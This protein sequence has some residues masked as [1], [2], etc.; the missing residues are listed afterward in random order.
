[1]ARTVASRVAVGEHAVRFSSMDDVKPERAAVQGKDARPIWCRQMTT[2]TMHVGCSITGTVIGAGI[3]TG[4]IYFLFEDTVGGIVKAGVYNLPDASPDLAAKTFP[5]G[6]SLAIVEP[7]LKRGSDGRPFIRIEQPSDLRLDV[8]LPD[9]DPDAWQREGKQFFTHGLHLAAIECWDRALATSATLGAIALLATNR[10]AALLQCSRAAEAVR[11]SAIAIVLDAQPKAACRLVAGLVSLDLLDAAKPLAAQFACRWP[12]IK[13]ILEKSCDGEQPN[14]RSRDTTEALFWED[15]RIVSL[16]MT[17][18]SI[19]TDTGC[20]AEDTWETLKTRGNALFRSGSCVAAVDMYSL[21]LQLVGATPLVKLLANKAAAYMHIKRHDDALLNATVAIALDPTDV[22]SWYRRAS[23]L[24]KLDRHKAALVACERGRRL[25]AASGGERPFEILEKGITTS[26][27]AVTALGKTQKPTVTTAEQKK[28]LDEMRSHTTK[29]DVMDAGQ[30]AMMN[31]MMIDALPVKK[32]IELFGR[33]VPPMPPFHKEFPKHCG[34]PTGV[35]VSWAKDV[36]VPSSKHT[37]QRACLQLP[38]LSF[39]ITA[40]A[41]ARAQMLLHWYE[42]SRAL[43]YI[44]QVTMSHQSYEPP[45]ADLMKRANGV[46]DRLKWLMSPGKV[47]DICPEGIGHREN[48]RYPTFLRQSF[49]NQAYRREMLHRGTVH[50]A[51]GFV[52]LG[53]LLSCTLG[54][55]PANATRGG[56][57]QFV[58]VELSAYAVAKSLAVWQMIKLASSADAVLQVWYSATWEA[59]TEPIFRKAVSAARANSVVYQGNADVSQIF[60][61]WLASKGVPLSKARAEWAKSTSKAGAEIGNM[62]SQQD[63]LEMTAYELT[64][65]AFVGASKQLCGSICW[66]DCPDGTPPCDIEQKFL[67][68]VDLRLALQERR[69]SESVLSASQ[70]YLRRRV[71]QMREWAHTGSVSIGPMLIG[72]VSCF[73]KA[74]ADLKPWTMSWSNVLDY[75]PPREFHALA[76]ACSIH[77]DTIHFAYS[78][79][80]TA[81][82]KGTQLLDY[83]EPKA[84]KDLFDIAQDSMQTLYR[85]LGWLSI[86]RCPPPENPMNIVGFALTKM[87]YRSWINHWFESARAVGPCQL[88]NLEPAMWSPL[89]K[90]GS[91]TVLLTFTYDPEITFNEANGIIEDRDSFGSYVDSLSLPRARAALRSM[92]QMDLSD[93]APACERKQH[94]QMLEKGIPMLEARIAALQA[95]S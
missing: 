18:A 59:T 71:E 54:D 68:A 41:C 73:K 34:W 20:D 15:E 69:P 10:A 74:I 87:H 48:V 17:D 23:A 12:Q 4:G 55:A 8:C 52:D 53:V 60:D 2:G 40:A 57:L 91:T 80:W 42:Q 90:T 47:G 56:P 44:M 82:V 70:T 75:I 11:D 7:F 58:G 67:S 3:Y 25:A 88:G 38:R 5:E 43:P 1:M 19:L 16:L 65:D 76:R 95:S 66:W 22:K 81:E 26:S 9:K 86:F 30:L 79:N 27:S 29:A 36:S 35:D 21:A 46:P 94:M 28:Q 32:Q 63:R 83:P 33:K 50:V 6:R 92:L 37:Q 89:T 45:I 62:I 77:G 93:D 14:W 84:R 31:M 78:M 64:G 13:S 24:L 85:E 51:V 49:S 61:H 39:L 72:N